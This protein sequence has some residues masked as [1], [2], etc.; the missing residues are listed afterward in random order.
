MD[1][2]I[3]WKLHFW[4]YVKG[5]NMGDRC[6]N[7]LVL[8]SVDQKIQLTQNFEIIFECLAKYKPK[9]LGRM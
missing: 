1:L 6:Q 4:I 8:N 9:R 7:E 3:I 2:N 5:I